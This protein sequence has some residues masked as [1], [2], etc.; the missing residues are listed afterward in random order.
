MEIHVDWKRS[1]LCLSERRYL[2]KIVNLFGMNIISLFVRLSIT[3]FLT[4]EDGMAIIK[5]ISYFSIIGSLLP[6]MI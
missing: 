3:H 4:I 1:R 5:K 2:E 6:M